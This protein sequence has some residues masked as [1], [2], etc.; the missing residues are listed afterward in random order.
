MIGV[1]CK[2][3]NINERA[4]EFKLPSAP[5]SA[6]GFM[7]K[8]YFIGEDL[9]QS[10]WLTIVIRGHAGTCAV[11]GSPYPAR[12]EIRGK[13]RLQLGVSRLAQIC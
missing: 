5:G 2:A 6:G 8:H 4:R 9:R 1:G 13:E 3:C 10:R 7:R 12:N 11:R